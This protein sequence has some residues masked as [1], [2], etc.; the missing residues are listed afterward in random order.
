MDKNNIVHV[1]AFSEK[2]QDVGGS[3]R[4]I[5]RL[6]DDYSDPEDSEDLDSDVDNQ[7]KSIFGQEE[8]R[9]QRRRSLAMPNGD[10]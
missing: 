3:N 9:K 4:N 8:K 5:R 2:K 1:S 10:P 6:D 7:Q